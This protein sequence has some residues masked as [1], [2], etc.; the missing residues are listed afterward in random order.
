MSLEI[1][2]MT[3]RELADQYR[4]GRLS[5]VEATDAVLDRI[6]RL[7]PQ[8]NAFVGTDADFARDQAKASEKRWCKKSPLGAIDGVP[9]TIKDIVDVS[10]W[11]TRKGSLSTEKV[12]PARRDAPAVAL[13]R[14]EGAVILGKTTTPEYGWKAVTDSP[15]S[16]ITRNPWDLT[17]T[18][19]GSSG[20]AAAAAALGLGALH[21]GTDG[22]GSIR[23]PAA[24]TG[25]VG[26]KPT[27]GRVP[28]YPPSV[29]GTL[30]HIGPMTRSVYDAALMLQAF[31]RK[32]RDDWYSLPD[33]G[34]YLPS[35]TTED[36]GVSGMRFAYVTGDKRVAVD[37]LIQQ[38][39][40]RVLALIESMGGH[41]E[42]VEIPLG[43]AEDVFR[44]LWYV[45]ANQLFRTLPIDEQTH[46]DPGFVEVATEANHYDLMD[47][48]DAT[49]AREAIGRSLA[50]VFD[51]VDFIVTPTVPIFPF[52]AGRETPW[53][54]EYARWYEWA[55]FSFPFNLSQQPA[56]SIPC[57]FSTNGLPVGVQ[58]IGEK[59]QDSAVLRT[60]YTLERALNVKAP[61]P[62]WS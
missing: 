60:A 22:G 24:F 8:V 16:G 17:K 44:T 23:I 35:M 54:G 59:Y 21:L 57:S 1:C 41:I 34:N 7:D 10:G 25:T 56:I 6:S 38:S 11:T 46:L 45:G 39:F 27:F 3:A 58:I 52:D 5:P 48:M 4:L 2:L 53:D 31:A 42:P 55:S 12:P 30:A 28:A 32:H 62:L 61:E 14:S 49:R 47:F 36:T 20:G 33:E 26:L 13:L 15:F 29:F 43:L 9:S 40:D 51:T 18:P 19:G 50:K 37:P